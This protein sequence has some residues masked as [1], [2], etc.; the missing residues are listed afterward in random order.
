[1]WPLTGP[2]VGHGLG[3]PSLPL[4]RAR[5][6]VVGS[7]EGVSDYP[8]ARCP[9]HV[10][11]WNLARCLVGMSFFLMSGCSLCWLTFR[12]LLGVDVVANDMVLGLGVDVVLA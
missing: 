8:V 5:L 9:S 12:A 7:S 11:S 4:F 6:L 3:L 1:M 2:G 10:V